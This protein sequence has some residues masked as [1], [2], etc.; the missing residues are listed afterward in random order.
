MHAA[1]SRIN[2]HPPTSFYSPLDG[3]PLL[4]AFLTYFG[5]LFL[6]IR[7]W[8]QAD[9]LQ[10]AAKPVGDREHGA[11]G[12]GVDADLAVPAALGM[13]LA[14]II[15]LSVQLASPWVPEHDRP[16]SALR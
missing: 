13:M 7:W 10:L 9:P 15:S 1:Q 4:P 12:L 5:I 14:A 11:G 3:S 8:R 6:L 16:S 2:P